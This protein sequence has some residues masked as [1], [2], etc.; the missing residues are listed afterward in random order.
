MFYVGQKVCCVGLGGK[1]GNMTPQQ[2]AL[3]RINLPVV[4]KIYTVESI[5][6]APGGRECLRLVELKNGHVP[7]TTGDV[8]GFVSYMFKPVVE[9]KTDISI[10]KAMLNPK[11]AEIDA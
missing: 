9:R 7:T 1:Q 5:F 10:F 4:G 11:T 2:A 8:L 3:H 6:T